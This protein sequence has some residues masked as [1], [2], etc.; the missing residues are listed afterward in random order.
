MVS[1][2]WSSVQPSPRGQPG[3]PSAKSLHIEMLDGAMQQYEENAGQR[4]RPGLGDDV[5]RSPFVGF[6]HALS[7]SGCGRRCAPS[8]PWAMNMMPGP[9]GAICPP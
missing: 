2:T 1:A 7:Q 9:D 8:A 5:V 3:C 6:H 4:C